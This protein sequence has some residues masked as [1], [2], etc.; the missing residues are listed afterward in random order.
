MHVRHRLI[1]DI[2]DTAMRSIIDTIPPP[3]FAHAYWKRRVHQHP[4]PHHISIAKLCLESII[5]C[6]RQEFKQH[7]GHVDSSV[8]NTIH[9]QKVHAVG[10][11]SLPV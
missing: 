5:S 3:E 7:Y 6:W 4:P 8:K 1:I 11:S 2:I 10:T 9:I